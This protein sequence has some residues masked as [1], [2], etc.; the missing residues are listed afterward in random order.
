LR[1]NLR[2]TII[3]YLTGCRNGSDRFRYCVKSELFKHNNLEYAC[4]IT[5]QCVNR[6]KNICKYNNPKNIQTMCDDNGHYE[7]TLTI[8]RVVL[9]CVFA[10]RR[11]FLRKTFFNRTLTDS[12]ACIKSAFTVD[13]GFPVIRMVNVSSFSEAIKLPNQDLF[14]SSGDDSGCGLYGTGSIST[15]CSRE[16]RKHQIINASDNS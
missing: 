3:I 16:T 5:R 8:T 1:S 12:R 9:Y 14:V 13:K 4:R 11:I 15:V 10:S 7:V 6:T 2:H